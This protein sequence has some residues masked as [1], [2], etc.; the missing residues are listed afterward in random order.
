MSFLRPYSLSAR[1]TRM[2]L[3]VS[4]AVLLLA[5]L[6]FFSYDLLSFRQTLI[7]NLDA[8]AQIVGEN[9]IAAIEFNDP[10]SAATT[11]NSL[12]RAP[13]VSGA[14]LVTGD[15]LVLARYGTATPANEDFHWAGSKEDDHVQSSGIHVSLAHRIVFNGKSIGYV[16]ISATLTEIRQRA[17]R[18]LLITLVILVLC[19]AAALMISAIARRLIAQPI[20]ALADTALVVS[21]DRDYSV[22][23]EIDADSSEIGV[24]IDAFNTMLAQ[25]QER[26]A[27]LNEARNGLELR[28]EQRTI[29]LQAANRELEAFSY[30][31]AHDLR[32]PLDTI[33][34]IAALL[35]HPSQ[36]SDDDTE[37]S[38]LDMLRTS[39]VNMGTLI[40]DL[41][42]FARSSTV[43]A[44]FK[45]VDL[46]A[47]A[48]E[49]ASELRA[50]D[51]SR[52]VEFVIAETQEVLADA[53]LMRIVLD[54]L[55]R[56]AWKYTSH[57]AH[58]CVEFGTKRA[59]AGNG[60]TD[61]IV[62]FLRDDGAGFDPDHAE[63][64]FQPFQ[65]LH[66][67]SE[68]PGTGIGLATVRRVL[69]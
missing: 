61:Q 53:G 46:S 57:H 34:N 3:F 50:A 40:D 4:G 43:R 49:I 69:D 67:K 25:I 1:L 59:V 38:M 58:A 48:R 68:F 37:R 9:T 24:L 12:D 17:Y 20:I 45:P 28:V 51:P 21:R 32:G 22:R 15:G 23:A 41:L 19:M 62:Y 26:D 31:V 13:D 60:P 63:R 7:K 8:E 6:A 52:Q 56:N 39:T 14:T 44:E 2:N 16:Y 33:G 18:Y 54:N 66:G 42:S 10:Q 65:R 11:L 5:A 47:I 64:L 35:G 27:A 30:T 29:E 55:L 36:P